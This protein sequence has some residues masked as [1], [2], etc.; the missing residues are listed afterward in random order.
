MYSYGAPGTSSEFSFS[1]GNLLPNY[2]GDCTLTDD[3]AYLLG[4]FTTNYEVN[5]AV[6]LY[7]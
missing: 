7:E 6:N 3:N 4:L 2:Y 5:R 1:D